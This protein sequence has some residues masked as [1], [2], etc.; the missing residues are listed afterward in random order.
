MNFPAEI[1]C[2]A[3]NKNLYGIQTDLLVG[4]EKLE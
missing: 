1:R 3:V 2:A 4:Q